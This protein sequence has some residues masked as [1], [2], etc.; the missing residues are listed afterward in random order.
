MVR[1]LDSP[2]YIS[3]IIGLRPINTTNIQCIM[4]IQ[5]DKYIVQ[6]MA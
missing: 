4:F 5:I 6:T 3:L 2:A 1:G